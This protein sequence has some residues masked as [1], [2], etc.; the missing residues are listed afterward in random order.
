[1]GD[2]Y[3]SDVIDLHRDIMPYQIVQIFSGVGS[4]KNT[5]VNRLAEMKTEN[6][7]PYNI[8]LITSR[9][10][11]A[12]AQAIKMNATRWV[13]LDKF[14]GEG[15]GNKRQIKAVCT[16]SGIDKFIK[17]QYKK[18]E[19]KSHI[20]NE[21]DFIIL[22]EAHSLAADATFSNAPFYVEQFIKWSAHENPNC[23]II[24]M[25]GTPEPFDW[26]FSEKTKADSRFHTFDWRQE[27]K[28]VEPKEIF[29]ETEIGVQQDI[30]EKWKQGEK[31]IYF[32]SSIEKIKSILDWLTRQEKSIINDIAIAYSSDEKDKLFQGKYDALIEK[33]SVIQEALENKELLPDDVRIFLTTSKNKE[34]VNINNSDIKV[35]YAD[36]TQ[37]TELIQMAGRVR[38]GLDSLHIVYDAPWYFRADSKLDIMVDEYCMEAVTKAIEEYKGFKHNVN[39]I[40]AKKEYASYKEPLLSDEKVIAKIEATFSSIKYDCFREKLLRYEGRVRGFE[41]LRKDTLFLHE[42]VETWTE[43]MCRNIGITDGC[44]GEKRFAN[45]F[46]NAVLHMPI[47]PNRT[48]DC[49]A[50][51]TFQFG[52][53]LIENDYLEKEI[54]SSQRD[55]A[56]EK[57][58][59]LLKPLDAGELKKCGISYPIKKLKPALK[60]L[61]L[62]ID[63]VGT[64]K[65]GK[66]RH[67]I[68]RL[69]EKK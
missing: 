58:N 39:S 50:Y 54:T 16:N 14:V 57:L 34:G 27:C 22:D 13:D 23:H 69:G 61:G 5:W 28:S 40:H 68:S 65:T 15:I 10:T 41:Q 48:Y 60:K 42:C 17:N 46:P 56:I 35:M 33:K 19:S 62:T 37:R 26:M 29:I 12:N 20:W 63:D 66:E 25:S 49:K 55:K 38:N 52:A 31:V 2:K 64:H 9:K 51:I 36:S 53:W 21:L 11:T 45:W 8:L 44:T 4:G 59:E 7:R 43:G 47:T 32:V 18:T 67:I 1:M 30:F 6:G 24:L 3:L